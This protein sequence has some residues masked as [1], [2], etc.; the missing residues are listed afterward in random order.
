MATKKAP[1]K[2]TKSTAG[3]STKQN[4]I[5]PT[6]ANG[7]VD[8]DVAAVG[9]DLQDTLVE[10]TDLHLRAKQAHWNVVGRHFRQLHLQLDEVTE[11]LRNAADLVAER[12]VAIGYA[13]DGRPGTV[14]KATPLA[15]FPPGQVLDDAVVDL[16][17]D[18]LAHVCGTVRHRVEHTEQLDQATQDL[19]IEVLQTLEK[20]HWMFTAQKVT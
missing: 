13:P 2:A 19:L 11:D 1:A 16:M 6:K 7:L 3:A 17:V 14:A 8:V 9:Q 5:R 15:E 12:A 20:H 10:L 4:I 18:A